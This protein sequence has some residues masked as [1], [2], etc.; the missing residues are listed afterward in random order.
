[1]A[2]QKWHYGGAMALTEQAQKGEAVGKIP[3]KMVIHNG[4]DGRAWDNELPSCLV[5]CP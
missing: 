4:S 3:D 1:M 5:M 2:C